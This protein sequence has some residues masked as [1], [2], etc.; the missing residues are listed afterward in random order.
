[1]SCPS[2]GLSLMSTSLYGWLAILLLMPP[3]ASAAEDAKPPRLVQGRPISQWVA[4]LRSKQLPLR[5]EAITALGEAGPAASV[6]VPA[7][8]S[9]FREKEA[10]LLQPL[11]AMALARIGARAIPLL[12]RAL[13]DESPETRAGAALALGLMGRPAQGTAPAL[14]RLLLD[15]HR[16]VRTTAAG[17]LRGVCP[18][19]RE[20][21]LAWLEEREE[22]GEGPPR[23]TPRAIV[24][25]RGAEIN[26]LI[27]MLLK[28]DRDLEQI[29]TALRRSLWKMWN[30][31]FQP[32]ELDKN[33]RQTSP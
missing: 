25:A 5:A 11:A 13:A 7:L 24:P 18:P 33:G 1:M 12:E 31:Q 17:A 23:E 10:S 4:S 9:V 19:R 21:V 6:A 2:A 28:I 22:Q 29:D 32:P 16:L 3:T 20:E 27:D 26:E 14:G 8:L 30:R 15:R